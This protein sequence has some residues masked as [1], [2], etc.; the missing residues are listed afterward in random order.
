MVPLC[1]AQHA[2][3]LSSSLVT[4]PIVVAT[5]DCLPMRG[6]HLIL[7]NDLAGKKVFPMPEVVDDPVCDCDP[8]VSPAAFCPSSVFPSV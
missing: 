3:Y 2:V 1:A 4:G 7:G 6:V 8:P 5:R